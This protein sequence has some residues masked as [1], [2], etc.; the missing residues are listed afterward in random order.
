MNAS[1]ICF[2]HAKGRCKHVVTQV[3]TN[4][5]NTKHKITERYCEV[6][7]MHL[8]DMEVSDGSVAGR[9]ACSSYECEDILEKY[10]FSSH[11]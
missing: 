5:K 6:L 4:P 1:E 11:F 8:D 9:T 10:R 3:Y 2:N 7:G